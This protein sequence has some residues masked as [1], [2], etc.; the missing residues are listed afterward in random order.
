MK[1]ISSLEPIKPH[2]TPAVIAKWISMWIKKPINES[3]DTYQAKRLLAVQELSK[4]NQSFPPV[5]YRALGVDND[6][7]TWQ[8]LDQYL[9]GDFP[10]SYAMSIDGVNGF[11]QCYPPKDEKRLCFRVRFQP[12]DILVNLHHLIESLP[13]KRLA[14]GD[15]LQSHLKQHEVIAA[16]GT[17]K[18][19]L[20]NGS[21]H[22]V[23]I[24]HPGES[25]VTLQKPR[26]STIKSP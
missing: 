18:K 5:G 19:A 15:D 8:D 22:V 14:L 1:I 9:N 24:I 17:L 11:L 23:G 4:L 6:V 2:A 20:Q 25:A 7:E 13:T 3:E 12:S 10:E 26:Q 21:L 16:Q